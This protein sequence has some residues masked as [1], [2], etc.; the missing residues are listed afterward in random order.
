M[1]CRGSGRVISNVEGAA[2]T[3][4]CPW[5]EG[6]G[7]RLGEIDAQARWRAEGTTPQDAP[8][9]TPDSAA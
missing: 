3:V 1:A 6:G 9:E 7:V 4:A 8:G 2:A 5:C